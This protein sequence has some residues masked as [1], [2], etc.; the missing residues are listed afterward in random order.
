MSMSQALLAEFT[1]EA[2]ST[3]KMLEVLPED[4]LGWQP[5]EKSMTLSRLAGHIAEI[6]LWASKMV[7]HD[8][9][10]MG[11]GNFQ[12][13]TPDTVAELLE[14]HD[15]NVA[16]FQGAVDG[17]DD[18]TLMKSW[19]L[20]TGDHEHL[21]MPCAIAMRSFILNHIVHH[22]GQLSV[23]LRHLDVPLPQVYG[24]TADSTDF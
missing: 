24:P 16:S 19:A 21:K 23:Y 18:E 9:L 14:A 13:L 1:H 5:H 10:D 22:R 12:P 4:K 15:T 2:G 6:P 20:R 3:R 8:E 11:E 17:A 7:G